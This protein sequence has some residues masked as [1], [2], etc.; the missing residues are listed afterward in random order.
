MDT[1]DY[2]DKIG[3]IFPLKQQIIDSQWEERPKT[4]NPGSFHGKYR[5]FHL[6]IK[7]SL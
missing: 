2:G 5:L 7:I 1:W 6:H 4:G 3:A